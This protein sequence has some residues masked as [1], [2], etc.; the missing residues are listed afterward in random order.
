ME[1]METIKIK[2][3]HPSELSKLKATGKRYKVLLPKNNF[4]GLLLVVTPQG[5]LN[6]VF[7]YQFQKKR[8]EL[9]LGSW[10]TKTV[11]VLRSIYEKARS[12]VANGIDP[13]ARKEEEQRQKEKENRLKEL[14]ETMEPLLPS[15]AN[16]YLD[17]KVKTLRPSTI[18]E[19]RRILDRYVF[20]IWPKVPPLAEIKITDLKRRDIKL[21][22]DHIANKMPNNYLRSPK[23]RSTKGA[24]TM[25][26]RIL[27]VISGLCRY[28]V[29]FEMIETNPA[30]GI[31]KPG[32]RKPRDRWLTMDEIGIVGRVLNN[33]APRLIRD[34]VYLA[35]YT[36]QRL[37]QIA[38]FKPSWIKEGWIEFPAQ[39]MKGGKSHKIPLT[40]QIKDLI[41]LRIK[42]KLVTGG[43]LFPGI[44][45]N[46]HAHPQALKRGLA[47]LFVNPERE[48]RIK[49]R[50]CWPIP[51]IKIIPPLTAADI[52]RFSF[53]DCRRTITTHLNR[54]GFYGLDKIVLGHAAFGVTEVYYQ[55][56]EFK[57]E[58]KKALKAWC[59]VVDAAV[60]GQ[61]Q[62]KV[63]QVDFS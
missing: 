51:K 27:A 31:T 60:S 8:R 37:S 12:A 53:H 33:E 29:E 26:N 41:D 58:L 30:H 9:S 4:P 55:R 56:Y 6:F 43:Y 16:D 10:P 44:K 2:R 28:A 21:L 62:E 19:Y 20:R 1:K 25:A 59:V 35:L 22:I 23:G 3:F 48:K 42:E 14:E 24:P 47:R 32:K 36:G 57:D 52:E 61:D 39:I 15:L 7:R 38:G 17:A 45:D 50:T 54:L 49:N 34:S 18:T 13:L 11:P 46:K 40:P 63:V 5:K